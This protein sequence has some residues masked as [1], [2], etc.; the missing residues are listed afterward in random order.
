MSSL[1]LPSIAA[2]RAMDLLHERKALIS[3]NGIAFWVWA[4]PDRVILIFDPAQID[5]R[6]VND[7]FAH[8][9]STRLSGRRVV[10]TNSRGLFLQVG[11]EIPIAPIELKSKP[12]ELSRQ[13]SPLHMPIGDTRNGELW[14]SLTEGDS[15]FVVGMRGM[16]KTGELHGMIQ[17]LLHGGQTLVYAWDGKQNAEYLRYVGRKN[18]TLLPM[19]G[20]QHGLEAIQQEVT[21]RMQKL[22]VSGHPNIISYNKEADEPMLPIALFIDEVA[23]VENQDLLLKHVKV[24]RAA[25]VHPIFATNDPSKS[26]V[27][28][29]S[30][31]GTRIS[32]KVV[33]A[34]ESLMGLG[35]PGAQRL[36]N[37]QGRGL[38]EH[39]GRLVEFQSF[40]VDYPKPTSEAIEWLASQNDAHFIDP[41]SKATEPVDEIK[42]MAERIREMWTPDMSGSAVARLLGF[43]QNGGSYAAKIKKVIDY[44]TSTTLPTTTQKM[45]EIG[46]LGA[47]EA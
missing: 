40:T 20:L 44:L 30:N 6:K 10:R 24:N 13:P 32:F 1:N 19:E 2:W 33:S 9:L 35:R 27:I 18:F 26:A 4:R 42:E 39:G 36:A 15:F 38:I 34:P 21:Q 16:G 12:L 41:V 37:V 3:Q 22:A 46:S 5:L 31:L 45:P 23:E 14:I 17:A 8:E 29:K 43:S 11:Y 28:A 25:G 47:V 7:V